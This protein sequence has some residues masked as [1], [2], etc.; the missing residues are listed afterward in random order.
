MNI[1]IDV[2]A[3]WLFVKE[4]DGEKGNKKEALPLF[5]GDILFKEKNPIDKMHPTAVESYNNSA[6]KVQYRETVKALMDGGYRE[7]DKHN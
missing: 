2:C 3:D 1:F 4:F 7:A 6:E 5:I